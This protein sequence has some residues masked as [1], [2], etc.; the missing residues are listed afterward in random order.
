MSDTDPLAPTLG[1]SDP[2]QPAQAGPRR[3]LRGALAT[4][5][6][7]LGIIAGMAAPTAVLVA[8][9]LVP[10]VA[11][12]AGLVVNAVYHRVCRPRKLCFPGTEL[13]VRV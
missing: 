1:A 8:A 6:L 4:V 12:V 9:L 13:C 10:A 7:A 2:K 11:G 5:V 3:T